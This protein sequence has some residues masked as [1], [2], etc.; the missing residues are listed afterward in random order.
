M[1]FQYIGTVSGAENASTDVTTIDCSSS[2]NVQAGDLLVAICGWLTHTFVST[3]PSVQLQKTTGSPANAFT[4]D[5]AD[6]CNG[7]A[8][9][10]LHSAIGYVLSAS[11]DAS[12][13]FRLTL[14]AGSWNWL[15]ILILQF[16]PTFGNVG[17]VVAKDTSIFT[18]GVPWGAMAS[19]NLTTLG[20]NE[21]GLAFMYTDTAIDQSIP[22]VTN[23]G[24]NGRLLPVTLS[25][26]AGTGIAYWNDTYTAPFTGQATGNIVLNGL[27]GGNNWN[28]HLVTFTGPPDV[29]RVGIHPRPQPRR[30][31]AA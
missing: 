5:A 1:G 15:E 26:G 30:R 14:G 23:G 19:G 6:K 11:A 22:Q 7:N 29:K 24:I 4:F 3:L 2:L 21:L 28:L 13:T 31:L 16:R 10:D 27:G 25:T 9:A 8:S 17:G 18:G 20:V 12:A